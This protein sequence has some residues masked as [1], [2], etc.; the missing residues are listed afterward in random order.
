MKNKKCID[1][2]CGRYNNGW[3]D[4]LQT[5]KNLQTTDCTKGIKMDNNSVLSKIID[6]DYMEYQK[7]DCFEKDLNAYEKLIM[8]QY[9]IH[10]NVSDGDK[11]SITKQFLNNLIDVITIIEKED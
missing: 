7:P 2:N 9:I 5:N 10:L 8:L 4:F 6:F 11:I 1:K 3:C